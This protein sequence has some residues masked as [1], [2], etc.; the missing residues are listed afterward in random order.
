MDK[1]NKMGESQSKHNADAVK[2][3]KATS[4]TS[5]TPASDAAQNKSCHTGKCSAPRKDGDKP[6]HKQDEDAGTC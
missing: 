2:N 5:H 6:M 4:H 3:E 1:N